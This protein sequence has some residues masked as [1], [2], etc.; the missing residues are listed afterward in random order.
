MQDIN[1]FTIPG[2]ERQILMQNFCEV[3]Q[4]IEEM[5][6]SLQEHTKQLNTH[7]ERLSAQTKELEVHS[8]QLLA[9]THEL[10]TH[11]EQF[12]DLADDIRQEAIDRVKED[13]KDRWFTF[14]MTLLSFFLGLAVDHWNEITEWAISLWRLVAG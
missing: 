2:S 6:K 7:N 4:H 5:D 10:H 12:H 13:K 11:N 3:C 8:D 1:P 14:F 9:Q